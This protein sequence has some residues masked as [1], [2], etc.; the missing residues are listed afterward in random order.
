MNNLNYLSLERNANSSNKFQSTLFVVPIG[1][2]DFQLTIDI[3]KLYFAQ[4]TR[5]DK[6]FWLIGIKMDKNAD[7]IS[8]ITTRFSVLDLDYDDDVYVYTLGGEF[9]FWFNLI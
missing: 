8:T 2:D 7:E 3:L 4:R 9:L 5:S 1:S 6:S